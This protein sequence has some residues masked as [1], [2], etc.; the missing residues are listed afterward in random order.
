PVVAR[1]SVSSSPTILTLTLHDALPI[2][3]RTDAGWRIPARSAES[4]RWSHSAS[5]C[6]NRAESSRG[7]A[8]DRGRRAC[9]DSAASRFRSD[10]RSEEHTSEL[11]SRENLVCRLLLEKKKK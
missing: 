4:S 7:R 11:Q 6:R 10:A 5:S 1:K 2:S 8:R 3:A 9:A